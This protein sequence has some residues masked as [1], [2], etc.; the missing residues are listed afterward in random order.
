M[1][2][3]KKDSDLVRTAGALVTRGYRDNYKRALLWLG[4]TSKEDTMRGM[5][6]TLRDAKKKGFVV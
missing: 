1:Q 4:R 3:K 6:A 5:S 2:G